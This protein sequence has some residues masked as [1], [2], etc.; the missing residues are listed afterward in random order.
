VVL[1][2]AAGRIAEE[3]LA[4][5]M[6]EAAGAAAAVP[7]GPVRDTYKRFQ[8][9][10]VLETLDR[11]GLVELLQPWIFERGALER[12]I[13]TVGEKAERCGGPIDLCRLAGLPVRLLRWPPSP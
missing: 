11:E 2:D 4:S 12:G 13:A 7:A 3:R 10:R 9:G 8:E 5:L 1:E 6:E